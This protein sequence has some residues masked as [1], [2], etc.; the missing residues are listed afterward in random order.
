RYMRSGAVIGQQFVLSAKRRRCSTCHHPWAECV[1]HR[2]PVALC[3]CGH[4]LSLRG[5]VAEFYWNSRRRQDQ[6]RER[7]RSTGANRR[8]K[9]NLNDNLAGRN[10]SKTETRLRSR[11]KEISA[12]LNQSEAPSRGE[13]GMCLGA[14][15]DKEIEDFLASIF[16]PGPGSIGSIMRDRMREH[17][18]ETVDTN[19][20]PRYA[21]VKPRRRNRHRGAPT[22][23][24]PFTAR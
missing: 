23:V 1:C 14:H 20:A 17:L 18:R 7:A 9:F 3:S 12:R 10:P 4:D 2:G 8:T 13:D 15:K 5:H 22:V 16:P 11:M 24:T 21:E 6:S 19:H